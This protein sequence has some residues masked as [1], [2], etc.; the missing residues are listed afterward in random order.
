MGIPRNF[1]ECSLSSVMRAACNGGA[2]GAAVKAFTVQT[3]YCADQS[4]CLVIAS[5]DFSHRLVIQVLLNCCSFA[6]VKKEIP[7]T[8]SPRAV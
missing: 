5:R 3:N 8:T 4:G 7:A 1:V 6:R 2:T